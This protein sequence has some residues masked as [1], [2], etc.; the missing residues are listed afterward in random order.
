MSLR[1]KYHMEDRE[2][3]SPYAVCT[4]EPGYNNICLYDTPP[5]A[6]DI[7]WYQLIPHRL[8]QHYI[9]WLEQDSFIAAQNC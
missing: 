2:S 6:A 4:V 9:T 5:I 8:P 7:L 1:K 3:L